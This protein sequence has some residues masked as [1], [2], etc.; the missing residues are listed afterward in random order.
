[1]T[2][3]ELLNKYYEVRVRHGQYPKPRELEEL[4]EAWDEL[5]GEDK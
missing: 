5:K 2:K 4:A 1:M 3:Q